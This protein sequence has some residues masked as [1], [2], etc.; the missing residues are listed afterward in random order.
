[1]KNILTKATILFISILLFSHIG[2]NSIATME[3][4]NHK[5]T[6]SGTLYYTIIS[7]G[8]IQRDERNLTLIP[9]QKYTLYAIRFTSVDSIPIVV[10]SFTTNKNGEF[11]VSLPAG[12]Y[13]FATVEEA[14]SGLSKGQCLPKSTQTDTNNIINSSVWECNMICP[15]EIDTNSIKNIEIINHRISFCVNCQ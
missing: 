4:T 11:S 12:K 14:K 2:A 10:K 9:L 13:G 15:L 5:L 6:I 7:R 8:G 1:M 3:N